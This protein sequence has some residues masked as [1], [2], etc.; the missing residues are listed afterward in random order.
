MRPGALGLAL[1]RVLSPGRR[2]PAFA[3]HPFDPCLGPAGRGRRPEGSHSAAA[4]NLRPGATRGWV[5]PALTG[6]R[7]AGL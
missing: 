7:S 5:I 3:R 4:G 2:F 1:P 6:V